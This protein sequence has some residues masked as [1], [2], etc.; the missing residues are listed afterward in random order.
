MRQPLNWH[1]D[2]QPRIK[3]LKLPHPWRRTILTI[4]YTLAMIAAGFLVV[5]A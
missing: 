2:Y 1:Y 3:P 4:V 5:L